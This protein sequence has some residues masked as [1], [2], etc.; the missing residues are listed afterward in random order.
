MDWFLY[1]NGLR[2]ER[3]NLYKYNYKLIVHVIPFKINT[4][5]KWA[6]N[7][8]RTKQHPEA[9]LLRFENN[10]LSSPTLSSRNNLFLKN[11]QKTSVSILM[12]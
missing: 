9:E 3:V 6:K 11:M 1:D 8:A 2:H 12:I 5:L 4:K 7:Q 10:F